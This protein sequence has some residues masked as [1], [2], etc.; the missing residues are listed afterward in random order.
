M[1]SVRSERRRSIRYKPMWGGFLVLFCFLLSGVAGTA[2]TISDVRINEFTSGS[3]DV[4]TGLHF[5]VTATVN[6]AYGVDLLDASVRWS[7]LD[8]ANTV[9][10]S[11]CH[12]YGDLTSD[13][14]SGRLDSWWATVPET[15]G[16]YTVKLELYENSP[17]GSSTSG[18]PLD[19]KTRTIV[20]ARGPTTTSVSASAGSSTEGEDVTFTARVTSTVGDPYYQSTAQ[21]D[22]DVESTWGEQLDGSVQFFL[23]GRPWDVP[24]ASQGN[25]DEASG[26]GWGVIVVSK[27]AALPRGQ[28][29]V[30]A[31]Y[32]SDIACHAGSRSSTIS[33][34]VNPAPP[35]PLEIT[36]T[37]LPDGTYG[38]AYSAT[39]EATGGVTPYTWSLTS[40][41][42]PEG[43]NLSPDGTISGTPTTTM[44]S[45]FTVRVRDD[46]NT[47][48]SRQFR[49]RILDR[50]ITVTADPQTKVYGE[51]DPALTYQVTAGS[52]VFSDSFTG[53]LSR[54]AGEDVGTYAIQQG[55]LSIDRIANYNLTFVS[56]ELA[57]IGRPITVTVDAKTKI[58]GE[59]DPAL[60]YQ[61]TAGSLAAGDSFTGA[62]TRNAG[63]DVGTYAITLGSLAIDDGNNGDNYN[64][65]FAPNDF[66]ITQR[67]LTLTSFVADTKVYDGSTSVTGDGFADDRVAGDDLVFSYTVAFEDEHVGT[68]KNV[69]FTN[70]AIT[71]GADKDN[72]NLV[73]TTGTATADI[74]RRT[75]TVTAD[76]QSKRF[77]EQPFT[78]FAASFRGFVAGEGAATLGGTLSFSGE[79]VRASEPGRYLIVPG[80]LTS[81]N[82]KIVYETGT[83]W[84]R[85]HYDI[86][87]IEGEFGFVDRAE[88]DGVGT[89]DDLLISAEYEVGQPIVIMFS[90]SGFYGEE[91]T[92]AGAMV[93]L[94]HKAFA[95]DEEELW[96]LSA[97]HVVPFDEEHGA[98]YLEIPTDKLEL[99]VY[100]VD[101]TVNDGQWFREVLQ[102]VEPKQME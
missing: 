1:F 79:A 57:I 68:D 30:H 10:S 75:I 35:A 90:I 3:V 85:P 76:D 77:D 25:W 38:T 16:T 58:Y 102:L 65:T 13:Y 78:Y 5:K 2:H 63:E 61:L 91:V 86:L 64:L 50:P 14:G 4:V 69:N 55:T 37:S 19:T 26:E 52:L 41:D 98:Y 82:Y 40:G 51:A 21:W 44:P 11:G 8:A 81:A 28:H 43:F 70:I 36:T 80:G 93:L 66:A 12:D 100:V 87:L 60:T 9:V 67:D 18:S 45:T 49:I 74:T 17:C 54:P 7:V 88:E 83:L 101:V 92:D 34:T 96:N 84:I 15:L 22:Y 97:L 56:N 24:I 39:I 46:D 23:N 72:Y 95:S 94:V 47:V 59:A 73:T 53:A 89:F 42:L 27:T 31:E 48:T 71:G 20:A 99:G 62:L 6:Q 29:S 33:H 32:S